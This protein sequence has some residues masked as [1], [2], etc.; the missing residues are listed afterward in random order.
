MVIINGSTDLDLDT[1]DGYHEG[2]GAPVYD[3]AEP[4]DHHPGE[5]EPAQVIRRLGIR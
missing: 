3:Q 4:P 5:N 2:Q 1:K